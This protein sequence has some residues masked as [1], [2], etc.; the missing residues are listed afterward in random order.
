MQR[1][2]FEDNSPL[3]RLR[4]LCRCPTWRSFFWR[5]GS[6]SASCGEQRKIRQRSRTCCTWEVDPHCKQ[7]Q[8]GLEQPAHF[9]TLKSNLPGECRIMSVDSMGLRASANIVYIKKSGRIK[10]LNFFFFFVPLETL[11]VV[12]IYLILNK[13]SITTFYM[14]KHFQHINLFQYVHKDIKQSPCVK[15]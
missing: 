15:S 1:F 2:H 7:T 6:S 9:T 8:A 10:G 12:I 11:S 5:R 4:S 14:R 13:Y 3:F